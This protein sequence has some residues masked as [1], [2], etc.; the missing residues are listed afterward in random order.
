MAGSRSNTERR[1][2]TRPCDEVTYEDVQSALRSQCGDILKQIPCA[3]VQLSLPLDGKGPRI[4]VSVVS[5]D[6]DKIPDTVE[7]TIRRRRLAIPLEAADDYEVF[8]AQ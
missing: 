4:R 6:L 3:N 2:R 1:G 5:A 7:L 8:K